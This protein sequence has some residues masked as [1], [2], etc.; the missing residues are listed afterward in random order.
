MDIRMSSGYISPDKKT[1]TFEV[2]VGVIVG[3]FTLHHIDGDKLNN[4]RILLKMT[5]Q[6]VRTGASGAES[7]ESSTSVIVNKDYTKILS[8]FFRSAADVMDEWY[9][10]SDDALEK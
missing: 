4:D 5:N 1:V 10:Q 3:R 9:K 8:H 2:N 6:A 7:A